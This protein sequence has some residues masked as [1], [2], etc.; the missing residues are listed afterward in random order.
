MDDD[1]II[2]LYLARD[3]RA[4][5]ETSGKYGHALQ[6]IAYRILGDFSAAEECENDA[7]LKVWN[8]IPPHEPRGYLFA[9]VARIVRFLAINECRKTSRE[10]QSAFICELSDE[11]LE[12]LPSDHNTEAEMNAAELKNLINR[13][14]ES[15]SKQQQIVFVRRYWYFD[16]ISEIAESCGFTQSKV[17]TMLFRM[18]KD[19]KEYLEKEGYRI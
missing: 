10:K 17:K 2:D 11:M 18:R 5:S 16:T 14:L 1:R 7:Y 13:Y 15:C 8:L 6:K 4:I 3:E 19:L 9:F 12:C